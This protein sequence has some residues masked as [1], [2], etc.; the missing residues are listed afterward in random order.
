[1]DSRTGKKIRM[2]RL[3]DSASH[4]SIIVAY[5][6]GV[7]MG[8]RPGMRTLDEM[9]RVAQAVRKANGL[10]VAPGLL[11]ALEDAYVGREAP[12][13]V[14]HF[15]YQSFS[16]GV[17]PYREG[18][19]VAL[20]EVEDVAAAGADALMTYLY[21]GFDDPEREKMEIERNARIARACERWGIV[22]MIEPRSAREAMHAEDKRDAGVM[23]MYCRISAEIGA[24][25]VKCIWP[26]DR[27]AF[28]QIVEGCPAPVLVAGGAKTEEPAA[29]HTVARQALEVGAAGIVFGRNIYEAADPAAELEN[30]RRIVHGVP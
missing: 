16:R 20:A 29:S 21:M 25:I 15:D 9:R 1:M 12:S 2:G 7:L 24:D 22:L 23:A 8:P 4:K 19:A 13:L 3:F 6:H 28:A 11:P 14:V 5:S 18:A 30:Y 17:L 26:G 10:M 27:G